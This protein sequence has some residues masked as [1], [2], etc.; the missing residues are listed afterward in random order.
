MLEHRRARRPSLNNSRPA[1][2][3]AFASEDSLLLADGSLE[4]Q[5]EHRFQFLRR[6][7]PLPISRHK[8]TIVASL[9]GGGSYD[10]FDMIGSFHRLGRRRP[11]ERSLAW[12]YRRGCV[13]YAPPE[14]Q[15]ATSI[16]PSDRASATET[17]PQHHIDQR[18]G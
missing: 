16:V 5:R 4:G 6:S 13:F 7:R 1:P 2:P 15:A 9:H 10:P 11:P 18:R 14:S 3:V 8:S 17:Q 12:P